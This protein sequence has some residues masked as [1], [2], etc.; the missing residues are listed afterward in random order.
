MVRS[1]FAKIKGLWDRNDPHE[2]TATDVKDAVP[3]ML[4]DGVAFQTM[5]SFASGPFLVAY[6]LILG[7][8][9]LII[10][11]LAALPF[12]GNI[13]HI[14]TSYLIEKIRKRK[15]IALTVSILGR[16]MFLLAAGLAFLKPDPVL[17]PW[18]LVACYFIRY[19]CDSAATYT[20]Y[21]WVR[22][23]LPPKIQ[24][25]YYAQRMKY[26]TFAVVICS[27]VGAGIID[28]WEKYWPESGVLSHLLLLVFA[29]IAGMTSVYFLSRVPEPQIHV[30]PDTI[31]F[32]KKLT[33]PFKVPNFRRLMTFLGIW[34][35]SVNLVAPFFTVVMIQVMDIP[36][37][38]VVLLTILS[39]VSGLFIISIWGAVAERFSNKSVLFLAVPVYMFAVFLWLFTRMPETHALTLP[40][41]VFIYLLI[42]VAT[43]GVNIATN[44]LTLK[45]APKGRATRYI[46]VNN[47]ITAICAG[48]APIIGGGCADYFKNIELSLIV[49]WKTASESFAFRTLSITYWD[50]FFIFTVLVGLISLLF[51]SQVKEQGEVKEATAL[52]DF[53][54]RTRR[55]ISQLGLLSASRLKLKDTSG[56]STVTIE[57]DTTEEEHA[58]W[59]S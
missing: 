36:L 45:L 52:Q 19:L 31:S 40:L 16:P 12:L 27:L 54:S 46:S 10:G 38:T 4:G 29:F 18:L 43:A 15:K 42:G 17:L 3:Y 13:A 25:Q 41:L 34:N 32:L 20:F 37:T 56:I 6:A 58:G 33:E 50:F 59:G 39:Q 48:T 8:N 2:I 35:F 51:L 11:V 55:S 5:E 22:D 26:M 44:N 21:S 9:N 28:I 23:L 24:P 14:P 7:A 47:F 53:L 1:F 49:Q 30:A 57:P